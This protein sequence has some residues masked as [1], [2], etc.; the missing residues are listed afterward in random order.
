[1]R[2][3]SPRRWSACLQ[4]APART[5]ISNRNPSRDLHARRATRPLSRAH[6]AR[7]RDDHAR[8]AQ[9][10]HQPAAGPP[11]RL[12]AP[13]RGTPASGYPAIE[14]GLH[15]VKDV[16]LGEDQSTLHGGQGPTVMAFLH[17]VAI[18]LLRRAG[19]HQIAACLREHPQDPAPRGGAGRHSASS[20]Y[21]H[22][23]SDRHT[24]GVWSRP[25]PGTCPEIG[26]GCALAG[27]SV[28]IRLLPRRGRPRCSTTGDGPS[29]LARHTANVRWEPAR[30]VPAHL[31]GRRAGCGR[32]LLVAEREGVEL[33]IPDE[34]GYWKIGVAGA[35]VHGVVDDD[36]ARDDGSARR[37][38]P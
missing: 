36:R 9:R 22:I 20:L 27:G 25:E 18:S 33:V 13:K 8:A 31:P 38:A 6:L 26:F 24:G 28:H 30:G 32:P 1:M 19:V 16:T 37:V 4:H 15:R 34:A 35:P 14:N 3:G 2:C 29:A 23:N 21:S 5:P 17:D 7:A 10:D 12:L 11:E